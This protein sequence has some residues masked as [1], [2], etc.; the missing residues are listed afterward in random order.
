MNSNLPPFAAVRHPVDDKTI[1]IKRGESGYYPVEGDITPEEYN[2]QRG[3]IVTPEQANELL[4][5]SMFGW[6]VPATTH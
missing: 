3:I 6:D 1:V 4:S 2:A 5:G